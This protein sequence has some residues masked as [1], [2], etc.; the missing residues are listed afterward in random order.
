LIQPLQQ[1]WGAINYV[2]LL[3]KDVILIGIAM[4]R[5]TSM[6]D[7]L[8]IYGSGNFMANMSWV[9]GDGVVG[10]KVGWRGGKRNSRHTSLFSFS[11]K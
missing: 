5:C 7:A 10:M 4:R 1:N 6:L 9:V 8:D 11:G 3:D 2:L